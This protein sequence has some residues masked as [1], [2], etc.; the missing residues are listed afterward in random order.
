MARPTERGL[1]WR[2]CRMPR[3]CRSRSSPTR[4]TAGFPAAINQGLSVARGEYLVL[5]NNDAVVTDA[6]LDQLIAL[7]SAGPRRADGT[8]E[9]TEST[10]EER[11][12]TNRT[13]LTNRK[14]DEWRDWPGRAD[15]ELCLAAATGGECAVSRHGGDAGVSP[16][17]GGTSIAG[18]GSRRGSCPGSACS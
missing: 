6:W 10:E 15:V 16:G 18:S 17:G 7:A 8:T 13:N 11:G 9:H 5:L 12:T 3:P 1:T 2:A 4:S 14:S